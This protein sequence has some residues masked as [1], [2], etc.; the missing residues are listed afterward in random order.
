M[1]GFR[2][3]RFHGGPD[4]LAAPPDAGV[5]MDELG[6]RVLGGQS[7]AEA[8]RDLLREGSQGRQGLQELARQA[9]DRRRQLENSGQLD[10]L[11][12]D[13]HITVTGADDLDALYREA[14]S[15]VR[16]MPRHGPKI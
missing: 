11:L 3:G 14:V 2:Y 1:S 15:G 8:L 9:R 4:P 16:L 10:G 13:L 12:Q 6:R 5:G 7:V